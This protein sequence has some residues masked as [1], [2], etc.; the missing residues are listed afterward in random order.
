MTRQQKITLVILA[1]LD[2]AV[3]GALGTHAIATTRRARM[4]QQEQVYDLVAGADPCVAAVLGALSDSGE[5]AFVDWSHAAAYIDVSQ[6]AP[7]AEDPP[8]EPI[9]GLLDRLPVGIEDLCPT[10]ATVTLSVHTG[11]PRRQTQTAVFP[12]AALMDWLRG[13][14]SD[15]ELAAQSHYRVA[16]EAPAPWRSR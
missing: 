2:I 8:A 13:E 1:L 11:T 12:G 16:S 3:M 4:P 7:V 15:D 14:L 5:V 10:P 9:W 6:P